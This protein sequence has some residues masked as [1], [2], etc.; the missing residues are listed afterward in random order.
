MSARIGSDEDRTIDGA[1]RTLLG[2]RTTL[3]PG[4]ALGVL[5]DLG[6][7]NG[8][9]GT[10]EA[11]DVLRRVVADGPDSQVRVGATAALAA[12]GTPE[13]VQVLREALTADDPA[14]QTASA[15][16][17]ARVGDADDLDRIAS[18]GDEV[19]EPSQR[20]QIAGAVRLLAHR[21]GRVTER[22]GD[23]KVLDPPQRA[24]PVETS[25][26]RVEV[27]DVAPTDR[28]LVTESMAPIATVLCAGTVHHVLVDRERIAVVAREAAVAAVVL[29]ANETTGQLFVRWLVLTDP[30]SDDGE[31]SIE[32]VQPRGDRIF[33]GRGR[34]DGERWEA[35]LGSVAR[36]GATAVS[37]KISGA[38]D[39]VRIDGVSDAVITVPRRIPTRI[40]AGEKLI[41]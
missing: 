20:A 32:V 41:R 35:E 39:E 27:R 2:E 28:P 31:V 17:L 15:V 12:I 8:E 29:G 34:I 6:T 23:E 19:R 16:G 24:R 33:V 26:P 13:A 18:L 3:S 11:I 4:A 30:S 36:P 40:A 10:K 21:V 38:A 25:E 5:A 1:L 9:D 7:R 22:D 37:I 14:L